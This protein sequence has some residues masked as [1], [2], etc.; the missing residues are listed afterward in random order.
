MF[1]NREDDL[2]NKLKNCI[3]SLKTETPLERIGENRM[4]NHYNSLKENHT[5]LNTHPLQSVNYQAYS[6]PIV[7][8]RQ[9]LVNK[10]NINEPSSAYPNRYGKIDIQTFAQP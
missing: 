5:G 7:Q 4:K 2:L 6:E 8:Q 10:N 9:P 1:G 3:G